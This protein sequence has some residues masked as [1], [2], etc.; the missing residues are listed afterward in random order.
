MLEALRLASGV[1][2]LIG[3]PTDNEVLLL[4]T[5][6]AGTVKG[7]AGW[8]PQAGGGV[9]GGGEG[10]QHL[11]QHEGT[12]AKKRTP[13]PSL[14]RQPTLF[15]LWEEH[16]RT[17]W[18]GEGRPGGYPGGSP[19]PICW[20]AQRAALLLTR[21]LLQKQRNL[22]WNRFLSCALLAGKDIRCLDS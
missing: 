6:A 14:T 20:L 11:L 21:C 10:A 1:K 18:H 8:E 12:P 7:G 16:G 9:G 17:S 19:A 15:L 4:F 13:P 3:G 22:P 2:K 5:K